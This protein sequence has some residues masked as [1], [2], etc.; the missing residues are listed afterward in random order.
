[1]PAML[2][3]P[4]WPIV[5]ILPAKGHVAAMPSIITQRL[6]EMTATEF[7][8]YAHAHLSETPSEAIFDPRTGRSW[9]RSDFD[10]NPDFLTDLA[11][12]DPPRPAAVLVP[13]IARA[14]LSVLLTVRAERLPTH[15]GQIAFPGGKVEGTD[16]GATAAALREA[17]EEVGLEAKYIEPLGYLDSYRSGTGFHIMPLVAL[18]DPHF[19]LTPDPSEVADT[20]EVPLAFLM[21]E[22]N[23]HKHTR[24]WKGGRLRH[25]YAMPF[26][27]RYIWGATA[28]II[29]NLHERMLAE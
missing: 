23:H 9:G 11:L 21:D 22:A 19:V 29:K 15:A 14:Q 2:P 8:Q 13:I 16:A 6:S 27:D 26:G 12:M 1:M 4:A 3:A 28:G 25:H 24:E 17:Y 20:F 10:L 7:R 18:I 5:A